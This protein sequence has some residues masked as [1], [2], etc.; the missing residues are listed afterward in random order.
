MNVFTGE[1]IRERREEMSVS[2]EYLAEEIGT[3]RQL[4]NEVECECVDEAIK[5]VEGKNDEYF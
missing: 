2:Q 5:I 1:A 4:I 3:Y